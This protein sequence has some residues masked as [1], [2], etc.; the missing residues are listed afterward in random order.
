M[1]IVK[2][3]E[4]DGGAMTE[5]GLAGKILKVNLWDRRVEIQRASAFP[6]QPK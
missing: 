6:K 1:G 5:C 3:D 2:W 4:R